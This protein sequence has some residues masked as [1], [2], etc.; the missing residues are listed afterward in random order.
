MTDRK[1]GR[2]PFLEDK[3]AG[4]VAGQPMMLDLVLLQLQGRDGA[5]ECDGRLGQ[6]AYMQ[7]LGSLP[8]TCD[9]KAAARAALAQIAWDEEPASGLAGFRALLAASLAVP[10]RPLALCMPRPC[11]RGGARARRVSLR[12][13]P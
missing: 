9:Y 12:G 13:W 3:G 7:W 5:A 4:S 8:G 2:G 1:A 10:V 11:R 6:L